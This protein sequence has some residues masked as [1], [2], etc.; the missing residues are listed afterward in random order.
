ML[1]TAYARWVFARLLRR[2]RPSLEEVAD[3]TWEIFPAQTGQERAAI[4]LEDAL[5]RITGFTPWNAPDYELKRVHGGAI[6]HVATKGHLLKSARISGPIVYC[7]AFKTLQGF[8]TERAFGAPPR[9]DPIQR[10]CLVSSFA[11]SHFFGPFLRDITVELIPDAGD[12]VIG[13][14]TK[15]YEHEAAYREMLS[16]PQPPKARNTTVSELTMYTDFGQNR[17]KQDRYR[18]LRRRLRARFP[19]HGSG[20]PGVYL[21]RGHSGEARILVNGEEVETALAARGFDIVE[22]GLLRAEEIVRRC[23]DARVIVSVEG[24]QVTHAAY[25]LADGGAYLVLQPPDRFAMAHK[26]VADCL[27]QRFAFDVGTPAEGGFV[28]DTGRLERLLDRL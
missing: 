14:E 2:R 4:Y 22:P 23:L 9:G 26:E 18:E 3:R 7:R 19:D 21:K 27:E 25:T 6:E 5:D 12:P 15:S 17:F 16:L 10:A 28:I 8:G 13:L 11:G 24:S 20:P 1:N